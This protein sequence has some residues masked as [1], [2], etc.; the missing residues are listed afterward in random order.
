MQRKEAVGQTWFGDVW[1][2]SETPAKLDARRWGIVPFILCPSYLLQSLSP[3]LPFVHL[4]AT[5]WIWRRGQ[6]GYGVETG[7]GDYGGLLWGGGGVDLME[8]A[9]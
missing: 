6:R 7:R 4:D 3:S 2:G 1:R 8:E 9:M 5:G